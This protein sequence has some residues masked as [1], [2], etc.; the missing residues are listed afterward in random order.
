M[1]TVIETIQT[2]YKKLFSIKLM[3]EAYENTGAAGSTINTALHIYPD[4]FTLNLF[5]NYDITYN[6]DGSMINCFMRVNGN[7][8]Y[9][10]IPPGIR[11]RLIVQNKAD[12]LHRTNITPAGSSKVY[13]F[14][15]SNNTIDGGVKYI[16]QNAAGVQDADLKAVGAVAADEKCFAVI[17]IIGEVASNDYRLFDTAGLRSPSFAV[18]FIKK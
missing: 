7:N 11:L 6:Y 10:T 18:K 3:H 8:P 12:F 17:D 16:T 2:T 5:S 4:K 14:T 13:V 9:K 15:N 1:A